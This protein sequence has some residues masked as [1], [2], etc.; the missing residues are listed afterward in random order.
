LWCLSL[1]FFASSS[2]D[3]A[4]RYFRRLFMLRPGPYGLNALVILIISA[5]A[6]VAIDIVQRNARDETPVL[7]WNAGARAF[8]YATLF[9]LIVIFSGAAPTPFIYF[10]F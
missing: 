1:V 7:R 8:V 5:V 9:V 4:A 2:F 3:S 10:Q 6:V